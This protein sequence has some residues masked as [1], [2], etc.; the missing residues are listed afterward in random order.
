MLQLQRSGFRYAV[1]A[2]WFILCWN[3]P[4]EKHLPQPYCTMWCFPERGQV[5]ATCLASSQGRQHVHGLCV[6]LCTA[7]KCVG[8]LL[9][10]VHL[11][12]QPY[13]L[14]PC[15]MCEQF[16]R[17]RSDRRWSGARW[18]A[19]RTT[20]HH[21]TWASAR[22]NRQR[23]KWERASMRQLEQCSGCEPRHVRI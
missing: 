8:A 4:D 7:R 14:R 3:S 13:L 5:D 11:L 9:T 16:S 20:W 23:F 1:Q 2:S 10:P 18:F 17:M 12:A 15:A 22:L 19:F 6:V 21:S